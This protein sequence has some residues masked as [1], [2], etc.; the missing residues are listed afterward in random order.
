MVSEVGF[1]RMIFQ[2]C[3]LV[4]NLWQLLRSGM[5]L[6]ALLKGKLLDYYLDLGMDVNDQV[7]LKALKGTYI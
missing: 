3:E 2:E 5:K 6:P 7:I 1:R 4:L